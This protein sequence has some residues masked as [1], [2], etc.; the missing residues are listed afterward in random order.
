MAIEDAQGG[1]LKRREAVP[2][3]RLADRAENQLLQPRDG[4]GDPRLGARGS[5]TIGVVHAGI[6]PCW[7]RPWT[8][9]FCARGPLPVSQS[10]AEFALDSARRANAGFQVG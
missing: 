3:R 4:I 10:W 6:V 1:E 9:E 7:S 5:L 8:D 2:G